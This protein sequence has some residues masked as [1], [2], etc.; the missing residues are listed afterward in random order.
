[1]NAEALRQ[2]LLKFLRPDQVFTDPAELVTYEIDAGLDRGRPDGLV[3]PDSVADVVKL[4]EWASQHGVPLVARGAG[5]GLSGGAVPQRGGLVVEF[6]RMNRVLEVHPRE[7]S[8]LVEPGVINL[9]LD[10]LVASQGLY[11]PPDPSSQRASTIGGNIGENAG[12]PHCFK[13]GVTTNYVKGLE[14]VLANGR[15]ARVGGPAYD[16]PEYDF[17]GLLVGSEGTLALVTAAY[18]RLIRRPPAVKTMMVVFD[19]LEAAGAAV[20][21]VIAAG[22]VPATL[23]MMDHKMIRIVE[24]FAHAGLPTEAEAVL[25]VEVDGYPEGLDT[26][27]EEIAAIMQA[28]GGHDIRIARSEAERAQIWY[29]RKSAAGAISRLAPAYYLVDVTVPRSQLA[30][31]LADVDAVCE[32]HGVQ[33]AHVFHAGDGNLHPL[34]LIPDPS[35]QAFIEKVKQAGKEIIELA[36]ARNGSITGEHGV[37][38]EKRHYMPLMH[39]QAELRA[40]WDVKAVFDPKGVLNPGKVLPEPPPPAPELVPGEPP[41][42]PTFVPETADEAAKGLAALG[43]LGRQARV[44][45]QRPDDLEPAAEYTWLSTAALTG[46]KTVARDDLY[47]TVGAGTPLSELQAHLAEIGM[48]VPLAAPWPGATVGGVVAANVNAPSRLR[49]GAVRDLLLCATVALADGRVVRAGRPVVKNVAGY[50]LPKVLVGSCGTLGV[51]TE[52][53]LKLV[54]LPRARRSL[55]VPVPSMS[56]GMAWGVRLLSTALVASAVVVWKG[57]DGGEEPFTLAYTAEGL[58]EE[59]DAEMRAVRSLLRDVKAPSPQAAEGTP[60]LERWAQTLTPDSPDA[61]AVRVGLPPRHLE[62]Y[63]QVASEWLEPAAIFVDVPHGL[64]YLQAR[65]SNEEAAHAWLKALTEHATA[66]GGYTWVMEAPSAWAI[67]ARRR[68]YR[69]DT[70][71]LMRALKQRW[72]PQGVLVDA[73]GLLRADGSS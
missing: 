21:A 64:L 62:R 9:E 2:S 20:S 43:A 23:E 11:F 52:V 65:F 1:M 19:S 29:A 35:D 40:M 54:P 8:A 61:L 28:H 38:T 37:G 73:W 56:E 6:A 27:V 10:T 53:T 17:T 67:T 47:V 41:A 55:T 32:R 39:N 22:L 4:A 69:P 12:G 14:F 15:T 66:L 72:D 49:Y 7:R 16:Y 34:L 25:I 5:T 63:V 42:A 59:V 45:G 71:D 44:T 36:L 50:D 57:N 24:E 46:I 58:P 48:H 18:L 26:Q 33:V 68:G 13:Y 60:A 70:L 3:L 30:S 31:M 51:L